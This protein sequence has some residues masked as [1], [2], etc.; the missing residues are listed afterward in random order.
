MKIG[1]DIYKFPYKRDKPVS[2]KIMGIILAV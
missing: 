1:E 2:D